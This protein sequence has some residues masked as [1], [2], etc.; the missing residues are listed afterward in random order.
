MAKIKSVRKNTSPKKL[1]KVINKPFA[2]GTMSSSQFFGMIRSCLRQKSRW[3]HSI[4]V[5]KERAKIPYKGV[6]KRRKFSYICELCKGEFDAKNINIHHT[7]ECGT[8]NSF[9]D[10]PGFVKRL[11]CD[12]D[13]LVCICTKCHDGIHNKNK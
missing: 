5:C 4:K 13:K 9:E 3:W 12:S 8:L 11:F 2:D 6:N 7:V 10:I 1:K